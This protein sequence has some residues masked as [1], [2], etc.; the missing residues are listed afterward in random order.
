IAHQWFGNLVTMKWWDDLWL[1]ESFATW[2]A[3]KMTHAN[4]PEWGMWLHAGESREI[5][6]R[7]DAR[8]ISHPIVHRAV[9]VDEAEAF[10]AIT[11]EKG[12]AVLRML[13]VYVGEDAF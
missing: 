5:A 4:H 7:L 6:M 13:E 11:Y 10:D 2:I 3:T 12:Q 9:T 1:N 8:A